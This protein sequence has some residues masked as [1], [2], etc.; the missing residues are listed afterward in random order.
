VSPLPNSRCQRRNSSLEDCSGSAVGERPTAGGVLTRASARCLAVQPR[1][2]SHERQ[3]E[4]ACEPGRERG[5]ARLT[6][7]CRTG[8]INPSGRRTPS[9]RRSRP[10]PERPSPSSPP[11]PVD[12]RRTRRQS[13]RHQPGRGRT[14]RLH[15]QH[16][17]GPGVSLPHLHAPRA[18]VLFMAGKPG[19]GTRVRAVAEG[20]HTCSTTDS[21]QAVGASPI[22]RATHARIAR[23]WQ[24]DG[25]RPSDGE[26][27]A[28]SHWTS[29]LAHGR[30]AISPPGPSTDGRPGPA[31]CRMLSAR[32][33]A[34]SRV[35]SKSTRLPAT[36]MHSAS[37]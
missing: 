22:C 14:F 18:G 16:L 19:V 21:G 27:H 24:C 4:D 29:L 23:A 34:A 6:S 26:P 13:W 32:T 2:H 5:R 12:L 37:P 3:G 11:S 7:R 8:R 10:Q 30:A 9:Q 31:V 36:S 20:F 17:K 28:P 35:T 1:S 15:C 25:A 33:P